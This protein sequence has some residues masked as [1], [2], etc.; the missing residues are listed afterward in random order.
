MRLENGRYAIKCEKQLHTY[1]NVFSLIFPAVG[2]ERFL[3]KSSLIILNKTKCE[4]SSDCSGDIEISLSKTKCLILPKKSQYLHDIAWRALE[5]SNGT[6]SIFSSDENKVS[7]K[8]ASYNMGLKDRNV[9][10]N[11]AKDIG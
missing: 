11:R 6:L 5:M 10:P 1:T 4:E 9:K 3:N 7:L 8:V 2:C